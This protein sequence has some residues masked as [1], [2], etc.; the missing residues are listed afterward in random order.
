MVGATLAAILALF[1]PDP[2]LL[3]DATRAGRPDRVAL[4]RGLSEAGLPRLA[5]ALLTEAL[6]AERTSPLKTAAALDLYPILLR[7]EVPPAR[8]L[9]S[10]DGAPDGDLSDRHRSA[11]AFLVGQSLLAARRPTAAIAQLGRVAP[12]TP[13]YAPARYLLGVASFRA[14]GG[15]LKTAG[16]FFKQAIVDAEFGPQSLVPAVRT[17]RRLALLGLARLHYEVG[18]LEVAL[19]YY[20]QLPVGA[21]ETVGAEFESAWA[22]LL[23]GD[24]QRALGAIHGA[25]RPGQHPARHELHLLAG[26]A[27]LALCQYPRGRSELTRLQKIYL[28][29]LEKLG[30]SADE[31]LRSDADPSVLVGPSSPLSRAAVGLLR[32]QPEVRAAE[33]QLAALD[34]EATMLK[35]YGTGGGFETAPL[36][37]RVKALR[38]VAEARRRSAIRAGARRLVADAARLSRKTGLLMV[39]LLEEE[40]KSL[41]AGIQAHRTGAIVKAKPREAPVL[42]LGAD[43]Q[44]WRF[45]GLPWAD[46]LG[47]YRSTTPSLCS[48]D[49]EGG[50]K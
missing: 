26:A 44:R 49:L 42:A 33:A 18:E 17:A 3:A 30:H 35:A 32:A 41:E 23:R 39:D 48:L 36:L 19:Y 34:A 7:G 25:R 16:A 43:W 4:A 24:L 11:R 31:H 21:P 10:L 9:A 37:V 14:R 38:V 12:G 27:Y 45:D 47:A 8:I 46:E 1:G 13:H 50:E 6:V 15:G 20:A 22:D 40:G 29:P 2:G 28:A 5:T